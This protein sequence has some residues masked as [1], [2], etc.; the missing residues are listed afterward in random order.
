MFARSFCSVISIL[1]LLQIACNRD[2]K[3]VRDKCLASGNQYFQSGK[4]KEASILYRRALQMDPRSGEAHYW[5][6]RVDLE[7]HHYDEALNSF[8]RACD[9]DPSNEDAA[10]RLGAIYLGAY[11]NDH[12]SNKWALE[13]GRT[14]VERILKKNPRSYEGLRLDA[15]L[16]AAANDRDGAIQKLRDAN[17]I[18]PWQPE[19]ITTLIQNL[20]LAG[21]RAEATKLGLEFISQNKTY[22]PVYDLLYL[23]YL[24]GGQ[25]QQA[26]DILKS[27]IANIPLD[28]LSRIE[29][30]AFY[31][32]RSRK[33]DMIGVL[34]NLRS[35]RKTFPQ[36]DALI[37]DF[38]V[39]IGDFDSAIQSYREGQKNLPKMNFAYDKRIAE[40]LMVAGRRDEATQ[41]VA[42]LH[43][44]N[45]SDVESSAMRAVLLAK[46]NP[47]EVQVAIGE[48]EALVNKDPGNAL[49]HMSL[50]RAYEAKGDRDSLDRARQH[51]QTAVLSNRNLLPAKQSL[52][53]VELE[54]GHN[55]EAVRYADEILQVSPANYQAKI[56]RAAGLTKMGEL[57]KAHDE[58]SGIL[59]TRDSAEVRFRLAWVDLASKRYEEATAGFQSLMRS[60]DVRGVIGLARCKEAE[61]Q[62]AAGIQILEREVG[63]NPEND[64]LRMAL[65]ETLYRSARF[66]DSKAQLERLLA[67]NPNAVETQLRMG[68]V[69]NRLGDKQG[70]I[71]HLR[72]A[73]ELQ[74]SNPGAA[75]G[76]ALM[77]DQS[78]Q[79]DQAR[80]AYEDV[81]KLD[82]E[83]VQALN[84]LAYIKAEDG[85][86]LD[87][88][89]GLVQRALQKSPNDPNISDTL[90]LIYVRKKL[91]V[92]AV[93]L[94]Q[95]LVARVP[96]NP[97]YRLHLAMA[98]YDKGEKA[99]AKK[100]LEAAQ[101][102]KPSAAEMAK[103][104]ELVA[105][106]G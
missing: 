65:A 27:K 91:T 73:R 101:K 96:D 28:G 85:L 89:L 44:E 25:P 106:I 86:D 75:Y 63:R 36:A 81:L 35:D 32:S 5:L 105:R 68:D 52:A 84:N 64:D 11:I 61:G 6:G 39:R 29:L 66:Q 51:L 98:L 17:D 8:R 78:G 88:A 72:K 2:P 97:A 55:R 99:Q 82:P 31:Y 54:I 62:M 18:K 1:G 53:E 20:A 38:Y 103:I 12:D 45:P 10:V 13:E 22:G 80:V 102:Y 26:E 41:L 104:R 24:Y 70:A 4:Y 94:L 14:V 59:K 90:G 100:E 49:L 57:G 92:Q 43:K 48:L 33:P 58:L 93:V 87:Q 30:A 74:P 56:T 47:Q 19:T 77:L 15:D 46:G 67:K 83:N 9:L 40:T 79:T 3:V 7:L 50:G 34:D 21:K 16:A 23:N 69:L 76:L 37:G 42:R 95:G 71:Q 60:G